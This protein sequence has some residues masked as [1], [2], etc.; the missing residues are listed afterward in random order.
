M[1]ADSFVPVLSIAMWISFGVGLV[2]LIYGASR[3]EGEN[4]FLLGLLSLG[5]GLMVWHKIAALQEA[6]D[7]SFISIVSLCGFYAPMLVVILT[8]GSLFRA[9]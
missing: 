9:F 2:A 6:K 7:W 3:P 5:C 8:L 1:K 4:D